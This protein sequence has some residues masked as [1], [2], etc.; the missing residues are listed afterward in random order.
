MTKLSEVLKRHY[1]RS[2]SRIFFK[3]GYS[4]NTLSL[5][6]WAKTGYRGFDS[7]LLSKTINGKSLLSAFQLQILISL[8]KLN[9][10]E[11]DELKKALAYDLL[12]KKGVTKLIRM[13]SFNDLFDFIKLIKKIRESGFPNYSIELINLL[14]KVIARDLYSYK[15]LEKSNINLNL[16]L[17]LIRSYGEIET[18]NSIYLLTNDYNGKLIEEAITTKDSYFI[19]MAYMNLGGC[20]YVANRWRESA[21]FL[22]LNYSRIG[23]KTKL[24]FT[25][26]LLLNYALLSDKKKYNITARNALRLLDRSDSIYL[27]EIS[28]LVEALARSFCLFG[29]IREARNLLKQVKVTEINPFFQ[30][31]LLRCRAMIL[32]REYKK[33]KRVDKSEL[34]FLQESTHSPLYST[35]KRHVNQVLKI[36]K[37][38][39]V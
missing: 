37:H 1:V 5:E 2:T 17:E 25:R 14:K 11:G 19:E 16:D 20:L 35:Y 31:Q 22:E 24:E 13:A 27:N 15:D 21:D 9:E 6:I 34:E 33:H 28:S 29:F 30:S 26:T 38:I 3:E 39:K 8:L 4:L 18:E 32:L 23:L 12:Q 36:I 7:S 10:Q